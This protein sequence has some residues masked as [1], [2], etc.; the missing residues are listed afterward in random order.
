M[1]VVFFWLR[2]LLINVINIFG[3]LVRNMMYYLVLYLLNLE[4]GGAG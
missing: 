3:G 4:F 2:Y 1:W